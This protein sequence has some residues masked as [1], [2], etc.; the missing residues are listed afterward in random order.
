[1][2]DVRAFHF[3][4]MTRVA[5]VDD[6][7]LN[8]LDARWGGRMRDPY[9]PWAAETFIHWEDENAPTID[10][11]LTE[12]GQELGATLKS[13]AEGAGGAALALAASKL[14]RRR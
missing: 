7:E 8:A 11:F 14:L 12:E 1:M 5:D 4:S 13:V 6:E 9:M 10:D 3:E 2:H